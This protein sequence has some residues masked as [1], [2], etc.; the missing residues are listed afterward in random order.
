M[1]PTLRIRLLGEFSLTYGEAPL[2]SIST[3]RLHSLL[4]YLILHRN[5][6]QARSHLAFCLWPDL[7]ETRA[8]ANLRKQLSF[9]RWMRI[10]SSGRPIARSR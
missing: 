5:A 3:P 2:T 4:T 8:R 9:C 1:Y 6:P 7:P 10:Q